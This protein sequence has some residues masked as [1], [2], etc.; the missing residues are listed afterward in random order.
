MQIEKE[1]G[2]DIDTLSLESGDDQ[3]ARRRVNML[4]QQFKPECH[5]KMNLMTMALAIHTCCLH[6]SLDKSL[7]VKNWQTQQV[8]FLNLCL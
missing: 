7:Q 4:T 3:H 6:V 1:T 8:P 2:P 5:I